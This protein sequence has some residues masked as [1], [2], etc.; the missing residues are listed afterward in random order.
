MAVQL[1]LINLP[2]C[3]PGSQAQAGY[4]EVF[5]QPEGDLHLELAP[6]KPEES[7]DIAG[8]QDRL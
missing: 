1:R 2:L 6:V 8:I 5:L 4:Q 3:G 7:G